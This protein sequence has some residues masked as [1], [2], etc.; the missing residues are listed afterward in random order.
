MAPDIRGAVEP[1][2]A[3]AADFK[4]GLDQIFKGSSACSIRSFIGTE[5]LTAVFRLKKEGRNHV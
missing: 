2:R 4:P 3:V 5:L 1:G